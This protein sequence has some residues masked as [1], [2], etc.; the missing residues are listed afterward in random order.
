MATCEDFLDD[1]RD[2]L[3][4]DGDTIVPEA[5]K[6]RL[7]NRGQ[8]AMFP[9]VFRIASDSTLVLAADTW[10]YNIPSAVGVNSRI[11][12]ID[13][14]D[15][16]GRLFPVVNYR[17]VDNLTAPI[18]QLTG[19]ALPGPVAANIRITAALPLTAFA[20]SA[21]TYT[22]PAYSEELPVLYAMS[23]IMS[24]E[25][26]RRFNNR[27]MPTVEG[28]NGM[29][30]EDSMTAAQFFMQQFQTQLDQIAMPIPAGI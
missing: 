16:N 5:T 27:R 1:I 3:D 20:S 21:S 18:L 12:Q 14:E 10:E 17:L 6:I 23:Q 8:A 28:I 19:S 30:A 7:L 15:A 29:T 13:V 22:G 9:K 11:I 4:D 26:E 2:R 24:R 25:I